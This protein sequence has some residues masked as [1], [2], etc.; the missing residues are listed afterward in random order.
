[1][2]GDEPDDLQDRALTYQQRM[3]GKR[4]LRVQAQAETPTL[5]VGPPTATTYAV[6]RGEQAVKVPLKMVLPGALLAAITL[7]FGLGA[8][9]LM[10]L[11]A[12][13]AENLL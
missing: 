5:T 9:L 1:F 4:Y 11:S 6:L 12:T 7:F 8:E 13:A 10:S 3:H 2:M